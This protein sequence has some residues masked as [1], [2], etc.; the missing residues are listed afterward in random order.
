M[1]IL[2]SDIN[3]RKNIMPDTKKQNGTFFN[4]V[5]NFS[6]AQSAINYSVILEEFRSAANNV[7]K[8]FV[9]KYSPVSRARYS[10][11]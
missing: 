5:V 4:S 8:L 1:C 6:T 2:N 3:D 7:G 9:H 11:L 10:F